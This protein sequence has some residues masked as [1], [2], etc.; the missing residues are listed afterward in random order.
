MMISVARLTCSGSFA[1]FAGV[2]IPHPATIVL[3]IIGGRGTTAFWTCSTPQSRT[4]KFYMPV[5]CCAERCC[6]AGVGHR[7]GDASANLAAGFFQGF[8]ISSSSSRTTVAEAA[9]A[10]TQPTGVVGALAVALLPL[11]AP[12][13]GV[14]RDS[15]DRMDCGCG[16]S[17]FNLSFTGSLSFANTTLSPT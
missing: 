2:V 13:P 14:S 4:D 1:C 3:A 9:G 5:M 16:E 17:R 10:R 8:L 11:A 12:P 7:W 6:R 15:Q